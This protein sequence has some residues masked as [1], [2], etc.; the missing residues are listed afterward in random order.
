MLEINKS[1]ACILVFG[2]LL[3][4]LQPVSGAEK[5]SRLGEYVGY[6]TEQYDGWRRSSQYVTVCD[7]SRIAI[8]YFRPTLANEP[9]CWF[10]GDVISP[11]AAFD[12][13]NIRPSTMVAL[14]TMSF[15]NRGS[16]VNGLTSK[17]AKLARLPTSMVPISSSLPI[18]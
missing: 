1:G 7:G 9:H 8:D 16:V 5:I 2:L 13:G 18:S 10:Y 6:S 3:L 11:I 4:L 12:M 17:T 14:T 15:S